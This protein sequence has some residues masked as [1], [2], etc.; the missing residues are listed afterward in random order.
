M[1]NSLGIFRGIVRSM[2]IVAL[3]CTDCSRGGDC[4]KW[5]YYS[6]AAG[7]G[8]GTLTYGQPPISKPYSA[9]PDPSA[10]PCM[11]AP[12]TCTSVSFGISYGPLPL[13]VTVTP[14]VNGQVITLPSPDVTVTA[15]LDESSAGLPYDG[16]V[17]KLG[18]AL[19]SG[20]LSVTVTLNNFDAHFDMTFTRPDGETVVI[21]NARA[22]LLNASLK[23]T[24][25]CF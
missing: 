20:S 21:Q 25:A 2:A 24:R 22:A 23:E 19:V 16:G 12:D 4:Q 11:Q 1:D 10:Y 6:G 3:F 7:P 8:D 17:W 9:G 5:E 14:F 13:D 18:L 15:Y